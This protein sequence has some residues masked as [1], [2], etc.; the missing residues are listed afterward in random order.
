M[1]LVR[2]RDAVAKQHVREEHAARH[3][4]G[5]RA[6]RVGAPSFL[7][8]EAATLAG[9]VPK[10]GHHLGARDR[11]RLDVDFERLDE[12]GLA[13][14]LVGHDQLKGGVEVRREDGVPDRLPKRL[15]LVAGDQ[16]AAQEE[17]DEG[18]RR[19]EHVRRG[20]RA[21]GDAD[22]VEGD[23]ARDVGE[24]ERAGKERGG[25]GAGR[26]GGA[27]GGHR[28]DDRSAEEGGEDAHREQVAERLGEQVGSRAVRAGAV[29]LEV[30]QPVSLPHVERH[31][32]REEEVEREEEDE[33]DAL[34]DGVEVGTVHL[35][36]RAANHRRHEGG[37]RDV[38]R[39]ER[40]VPTHQPQLAAREGAELH[41]ES[42]RPASAASAAAAGEGGGLRL[43]RVPVERRAARGGVGERVEPLAHRGRRVRERLE[44]GLG[45]V[46]GEG[47]EA[48]PA[49][50]KVG[51]E[52]AASA[53][54]GDGA[55]VQHPAARLHHHHARH[56]A[57]EALRRLVHREEDR[58]A[59]VRRLLERLEQQ[60][61]RHGVEARERLVGDQGA[62]A[63]ARAQHE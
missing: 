59:A 22:A 2:V 21:R 1:G 46:A 28:V 60:P 53:V 55:A 56:R 12:G 5:Q 57:H 26:I 50:V 13:K 3:P 41:P 45:G 27:Q 33:A 29:L 10:V 31:E 48:E 49:P 17:R 51:G 63:A 42:R 62:S 43:G 38:E 11:V 39:C 36:E 35:P 40:R 14:Q 18:V 15:E 25:G 54:A 20:G 23:R 58:A 47:G 8:E 52:R 34:D 19:G 37:H 30:D 4:A 32:R 6:E 7:A 9:L 44:D 24:G 16:E 61:R